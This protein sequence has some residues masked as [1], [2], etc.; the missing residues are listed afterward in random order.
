MFRRTRCL[1]LLPL[2]LGLTLGARQAFPQP[3]EPV[4]VTPAIRRSLDK[5]SI[6]RLRE[7]VRYLADDRLQ[8]RDTGTAG[9]ELAAQ[10]IAKEFRTMRL[11]PAGEGDSFLRPVPFE[12]SRQDADRSKLLLSR[13]GQSQTLSYGT[14]FILNG[15][16]TTDAQLEAPLVFAGYGITAPEFKHDDYNGL[17][18]KGK[19]VVLLSG[20]PPSSDPAFFDGDK[21]TKYALGSYKIQQ[22][23]ERGAVGVVTLLTSS[24]APK[25]SWDRARAGQ[26]RSV[27]TLAR[28][29]VNGFPTLLMRADGAEKL[30]QGAPLSFPQVDEQA[31]KGAVKGFPLPGKLRVEVSVHREPFRAPNVAGYLEGSD[32]EL[33]KQVVV[34]SAHYDHVGTGGDK[35]DKI[36]NGAWDNASGTA[37]VLEVARTF[38]N[39]PKEARPKRS[40]LF[41]LVTGEEHGLLG[42]RH[43]VA[44]PAF[45]IAQTAANINLDMTEIFGVPKDFNAL[46]VEHSSLQRT[47]EVV[48]RELG[49]KV[50]P[51]PTPELGTF[52]RSDQF[53]FVQAGVPSLFLRWG[54]E[55]EDIEPARVKKVH[56]EKLRTIYHQ[57]EDGFDPTWSWEGMRR[58][59]QVAFLLGLHVANQPGLP[60]WNADSNFNKPRAQPR[61]AD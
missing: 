55:Y 27:I 52:V 28:A 7:H 42:S 29:R 56:Q 41:L 12:R 35:E 33:K 20:E 57:V 13:D 31:E 26:V 24:R 4:L 30:F 9:G 47:A 50:G 8:G 58:H 36:F 15:F 14:D 60:T 59:T 43:Y 25:F 11:K 2:S 17:D 3:G 53:S 48:A 1:I 61:M 39:L 46:G 54:N 45:P 6:D 40:V 5:V 18:A 34:Y 49:M 38:S 21:D 37:G 10:Y 51:D 22:A 44:D 19:L 23:R 32:P 16:A